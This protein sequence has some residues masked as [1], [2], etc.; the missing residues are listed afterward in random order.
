MSNAVR[1]VLIL[2]AACGGGCASGPV[3]SSVA[4]E[5]PMRGSGPNWDEVDR[6]TERRRAR[7]SQGSP[8]PTVTKSV[9]Q[10]F[11]TMS[12]ADYETA[13]NQAR[14][15]VRKADPRMSADAVEAEAVKRA[16]KAKREYEHTYQ[17]RSSVG[18]EWTWSSR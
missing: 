15:D 6:G 13:L 3:G 14:E 2:G 17:T 12:D 16:D 4:S 1:A 9:E 11:F 5:P 7:T 8:G 18:V 10:G